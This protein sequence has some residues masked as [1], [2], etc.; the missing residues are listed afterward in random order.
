MVQAID[1]ALTIREM[2][3]HKVKLQKILSRITGKSEAQVRGR[4]TPFVEET[5]SFT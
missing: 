3:Y 5:P 1:I 4:F 2:N